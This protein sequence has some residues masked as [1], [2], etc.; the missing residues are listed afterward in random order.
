MPNLADPTHIFA[1]FSVFIQT[2]EKCMQIKYI[3]SGCATATSIFYTH[4]YKYL[5]K[6]QN[7]KLSAKLIK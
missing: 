4:S 5:K 2:G 1:E 7:A 6:I 3:Y